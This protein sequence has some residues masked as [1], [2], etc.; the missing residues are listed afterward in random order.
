MKLRP[1]MGGRELP[2]IRTEPQELGKDVLAEGRLGRILWRSGGSVKLVKQALDLWKEDVIQLRSRPRPGAF[3]RK[4]SN[5]MRHVRGLKY[6]RYGNG[7][8]SL[9]LGGL[10]NGKPHARRKENED[11]TVFQE[12]GL[13]GQR[14]RLK[15]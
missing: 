10:C 6:V 11:A 13:L 7:L 1:D 9:G 5:A 8:T 3:G 4:R 2:D 15:S 12:L 14:Y